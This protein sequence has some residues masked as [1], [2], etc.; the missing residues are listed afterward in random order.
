MRLQDLYGF[1]RLFTR[2]PH[3]FSPRGPRLAV[4]PGWRR[5]SAV[6]SA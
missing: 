3:S 2:I 5:D 6:P 4:T 1:D